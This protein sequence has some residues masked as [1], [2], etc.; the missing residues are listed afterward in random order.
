MLKSPI[1]EGIVRFIVLCEIQ[2]YNCRPTGMDFKHIFLHEV[3]FSTS[4]TE[5]QKER[6]AQ[7]SDKRATCNHVF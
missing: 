3:N 1:K 2:Y 4:L 7:A 5:S 6:I